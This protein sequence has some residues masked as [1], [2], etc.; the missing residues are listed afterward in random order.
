[1]ILSTNEELRLHIPSNAVDEVNLLQGILDNSEHDFLE[2]KLGTP[3]YNR[4]CEYYSTIT[5]SDF[6]IS[7]TGGDYKSDPWA[8]LLLASQRVVANDAF[9]RFAY[10]QIISVNGAGVNMASSNDYATADSKMLDK[11]VQGYKKEAMV[12]LNNLLLQLETWAEQVN[13]PM[14]IDEQNEGESVPKE[15]ENVQNKDENVPNEDENVQNEAIAE[16]VNLWQQSKYYYLHADLL[17]PT[18]AL[19]Q[20]FID[21]YENRDKF[22]RLLPDL[23]FIQDEYI[24]DAIGEDTVS[25]LLHSTD[26][27]D[28]KLLRKVRRLMVAYLEER[29]TVLAIDKQRRQQAHDEAV[30]LKESIMNMLKAREEANTHEATDTPADSASTAQSEGFKN[31]HEGS[32]MF[33]SPM[34]Y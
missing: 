31:N 15:D 4:L 26:P 28:E 22:I 25:A 33:V 2:D 18:C 13:S 16:I 5:P 1:M 17:I 21:I 10:Q 11:G 8:I 14:T 12:S 32:R 9:A 23:R 7:V 20:R 3:L 6:Y 27:A 34:L 29:T 24:A 19:L 30:S